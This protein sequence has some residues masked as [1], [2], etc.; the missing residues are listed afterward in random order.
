MLLINLLISSLFILQT[1]SAAA[2]PPI[3]DANILGKLLHLHLPK[4]GNPSKCD[5]SRAK[6]PKIGNGENLPS[7]PH[8]LKVKYTTL[9]VGTQNYTCANNNQAT[10]PVA[11]GAL[12]TLFDASCFVSPRHRGFLDVLAE[13]AAVTDV[14][15]FK[16]ILTVFLR[17][18]T[19]GMHYFVE[20]D[21]LFDMRSKYDDDYA[22]V[23]VVAKASAPGG[24]D[25][26]W[27]KLDRASE[28][29]GIQVR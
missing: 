28:G 26:D 24:D 15:I 29:S 4:D 1:A 13:I 27:L 11:I 7:P 21:P 10:K 18:K 3:P 20:S 2:L 23:D 25:V 19:V 16:R 5:L 17:L 6:L 9:G 14:N 12:A 22:F 8:G